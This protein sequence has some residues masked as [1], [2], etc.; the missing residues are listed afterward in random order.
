MSDT[1]EAPEGHDCA[2]KQRPPYVEQ[3]DRPVLHVQAPL[4][5]TC[6]NESQEL[7]QDPQYRMLL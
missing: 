2:S 5:Q 7:L 3:G 6:E 4:V 1:L